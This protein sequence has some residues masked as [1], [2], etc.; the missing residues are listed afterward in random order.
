MSVA[1]IGPKFYAW[2]R[3]GKPLAFGKLYTYQARTNVPKD[4]Y[5][6][7]DQEVANTNP[8]ILNGEGYANVYLDGSY[9]VV[10]KDSDDN[11][12][13][14]ADPVTANQAEEW[15]NC[16]TA[17]YLSSTTF[18]VTGNKVGEYDLGRRVRLDDNTPTYQYSTISN[19]VYAA[20][21]TTITVTDPVVNT[22]LIGSCTSIIGRDSRATESVLNFPTLQSAIESPLLQD[23]DAVNVKEKTS[24]NGGGSLWDAVL[25]SSVTTNGDN[26]VSCSGVPILALVQRKEGQVLG[27]VDRKYS[28]VAGVVRNTGGGWFIIDDGTHRNAN[29][30]SVS[31]NPNGT[32]QIDYPKEYNKI[33]SLIAAP[34]EALAQRGVMIGGSVGQSFSVFDITAAMSFYVDASDGSITGDSLFTPYL[35]A[36]ISSPQ[37]IVISHPNMIGAPVVTGLGSSGRNRAR[38]SFSSIQ[39]VIQELCDIGGYF[40]YNGASWDYLGDMLIPPTAVFAAGVLTITHAEAFDNVTVN[41][42]GRDGI[43]AQTGSTGTTSIQVKFYDIV[44]GAQ[45]MTETT[46]MKFHFRRNGQVQAKEVGGLYAVQLGVCKLDANDFV[47]ASGNFW[48]KGVFENDSAEG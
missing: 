6:S 15:N 33:V 14:S 41:V 3:N 19:S 1:M 46:A 42:T 30:A 26:I 40:Q 7:E 44:T 5:Q 9:K 13:W 12:I 45:I 35:S 48:I 47:S 23:G 37:Q 38:I 11:E 29:I 21:E 31:P 39:T 2:D 28:V 10:L 22:G 4:T 36:D 25:A 8:V 17:T 24:G 34:D 27:V 20:G 18:K 32:L 16:L 43:I